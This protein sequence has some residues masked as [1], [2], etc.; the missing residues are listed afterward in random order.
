MML[1]LQKIRNNEE[2]NVINMS[3]EGYTISQGVFEF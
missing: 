3:I 1:T 2:I